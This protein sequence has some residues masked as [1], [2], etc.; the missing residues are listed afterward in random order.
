MTQSAKAAV[1]SYYG[2]A[3]KYSYWNGCSS[4]GK[5]GLMEAQRFPE[6]YHSII[7]GAS[8]PPIAMKN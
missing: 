2:K 7:V 3:P 6:D 4:G 8:G 1:A 5:Q